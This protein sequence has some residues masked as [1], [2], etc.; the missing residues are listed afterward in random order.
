MFNIDPSIANGVSVSAPRSTAVPVSY[1]LR[2][3]GDSI[4]RIPVQSKT[5]LDLFKLPMELATKKKLPADLLAYADLLGQWIP[6]IYNDTN[7][8]HLNALTSQDARVVR[9]AGNVITAPFMFRNVHTGLIVTEDVLGIICCA[10]CPQHV[11]LEL[12]P[13]AVFE[14]VTGH[15]SHDMLDKETMLKDF[16]KALGHMFDMIIGQVSATRHRGGNNASST[17]IPGNQ[18]EEFVRSALAV[19]EARLLLHMDSAPA[20]M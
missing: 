12:L 7:R 11:L 3:S 6:E 15:R 1:D 9:D 17:V 19:W 20:M 10:E 4:V 18:I 5:H 14:K 8:D 16:K 2:V 13:G